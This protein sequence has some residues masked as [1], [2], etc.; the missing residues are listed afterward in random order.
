MRRFA[1]FIIA[2]AMIAGGSYLLFEQLTV[3]KI[4]FAK[5]L[6]SAFFLI[7]AGAALLWED[8]IAPMLRG[9]RKD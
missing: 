6:L 2:S 1:L 9:Q 4:I 3:S 8:F 7:F 5:F